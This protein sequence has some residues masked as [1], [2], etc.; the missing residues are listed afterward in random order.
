M[1]PE[2]PPQ[3]PLVETVRE[4]VADAELVE[5]A[6]TVE[7]WTVEDWTVEEGTVDEGAM[8]EETAVEE[9]AAE[10]EDTPQSPKPLRHPSPQ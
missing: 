8:E 1:K 4:A 3:A 10:D 2:S 9:A 5:D 7:D 6:T